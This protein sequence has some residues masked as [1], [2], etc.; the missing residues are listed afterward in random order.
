[1]MVPMTKMKPAM[2]ET[3]TIISKLIW[4]GI[5]VDDSLTLVRVLGTTKVPVD[6]KTGEHRQ[7]AEKLVKLNNC[8]Y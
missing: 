5:V 7:N 6:T 2:E 1:M 4:S 8:F 3:V